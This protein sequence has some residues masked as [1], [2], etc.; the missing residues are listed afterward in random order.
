M[1][2]KEKIQNALDGAIEEFSYN[3]PKEIYSECD[4]FWD[5]DL[6][7]KDGTELGGNSLVVDCKSAIYDLESVIMSNETALWPE[8][9]KEIKDCFS[10][11][12][13]N[14]E[15]TE[16]LNDSAENLDLSKSKFFVRIF[17]V[18][19]NGADVWKYHME[20]YIFADCLGENDD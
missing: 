4:M 3:P 13:E 2:I 1:T 9:M 10:N 18:V 15:D 8:V 7:L 20:P 19:D 6:V 16:F 12:F 14:M 5:I 11:L 17:E